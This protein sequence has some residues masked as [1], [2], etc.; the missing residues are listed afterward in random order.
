MLL[1]MHFYS[2]LN[3]YKIILRSLTLYP[4][5]KGIKPLQLYTIILM[6]NLSYFVFVCTFN[7]KK[8]V[9]LTFSIRKNTINAFPLY[10]SASDQID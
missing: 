7:K 10:C 2:F 4:R 1:L 3:L 8:I 9:E 5:M 6:N